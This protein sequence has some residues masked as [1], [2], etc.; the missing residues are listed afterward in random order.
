MFHLACLSQLQQ[1]HDGP[2]SI[3]VSKRNETPSRT[4]SRLECTLHAPA[5]ACELPYFCTQD[6][7][8]SARD[9]HGAAAGLQALVLSDN[10]RR[11]LR[12]LS[13]AGC[14]LVSCKGLLA[15]SKACSKSMKQLNI[16]RT[17][18]MSLRMFPKWVSAEYC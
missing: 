12:S 9:A 2:E 11:R 4:V 14:D 17:A 3:R 15:L 16:S 13:I 6:G 5:C 18:V 1:V 10:P 7:F 8:Q